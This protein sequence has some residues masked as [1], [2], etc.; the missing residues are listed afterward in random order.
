V[1]LELA[2]KQELAA[3]DWRQSRVPSIFQA[4]VVTYVL[5]TGEAPRALQAALFG[6][7]GG[8]ETAFTAAFITAIVLDLVRLAPLFVL[9]RHPLGILHPAII[10]LIL[11][12]LLVTMPTVLQEFG[13]IAGLF[14]AQPVTAP[15]YLALGWQSPEETWWAIAKYDLLQIA[16]L[17]SAYCGLA[18]SQ[19]R[20]SPLRIQGE[21]LNTSDLRRLT[22]TLIA[23]TVVAL[24]G[25]LS[26]RGGIDSH[27]ADL[28]RGRF[29]SLGG[30]GPLIVLFDLSLVA[31][32]IWVAA[33][34]DD[35]RTPLF[36]SAVVTVTA[37]QFLSNGSRTGS[38]TVLMLVGLT[39]ALRKRRIPW[40][41][42]LLLGPLL[43]LSL[44]IL[45]IARTSGIGGGSAT[46][47]VA[48]ASTSSALTA[49][50]EEIELR[51]SLTG[52]VPVVEDGFR[53]TDGPLLGRTYLAAVF[54]ALPRWVWEDKPRGPGSL[55]AQY[56]LGE[57]REGT[58]VP[59]GPTAEAYWNFGILG[60]IV[61]FFLYGVLLRKAHDLYMAN[62]RNPFV[63]TFFIVF[64][65]V[66]HMS[67]DAI[68]IFQQQ[69]LWMLVIFGLAK[70]TVRDDGVLRTRRHL[71]GPSP[72]ETPIPK[73][74]DAYP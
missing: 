48:S 45:A 62:D 12:P 22:I 52:A 50:Q 71:S 70:L 43:F 66:F 16:G 13:G 28:A 67:T 39:W 42:A 41:M 23:I 36:I 35:V 26:V 17:V 3:N 60:V 61:L 33:R 44:G 2:K 37:V 24:V 54:A 40:R 29:R 59:I 1:N 5:L 19:G 6:L 34:P 11:W 4:L 72:Q 25:F 46:E 73:P 65:T 8:G 21:T 10:A 55:Y 56:F 14:L 63:V 58:A 69:F 68:V 51:Q 31:L 32:L 38:L 49:I 57:V 64:A 18:L 27:L 53:V 30:M 15:Y 47:A 7:S 74:A 9:A 20:P